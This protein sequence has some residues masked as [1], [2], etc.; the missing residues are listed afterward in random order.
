MHLRETSRHVVIHTPAKL[1]L[2]FEVLARRSDGFHEV[3]TLVY[4][5]DLCDT[6]VMQRRDDERIA[7]RLLLQGHGSREGRVALGEVPSDSSNLVIRALELYRETERINQGCDVVLIKR[8]P[9]EAGLGGGSS[10]AAAALVGANRVWGPR[11]PGGRLT[12]LGAILGS[13]VPLFFREGASVCR[14][15]GEMVEG[16]GSSPVLHFALVRPPVGLSTAEV[17]GAC[18]VARAPQPLEPFLEAFTAGELRGIGGLLFNRLEGA[19]DDLTPWIARVRRAFSELDCVGHQMTGSGSSYFGLCRH[20]RHARRVAR[21]L[22]T[23]GLGRAYAV[24]GCR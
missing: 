8:I 16:T 10:D 24:R 21:R 7:F 17:Y 19:A 11:L 6:L 20:A 1:N 13:D 23:Y 15:R 14:G 2:F 3:E 4:P 22:D 18:E 5:I 9:S 12:E